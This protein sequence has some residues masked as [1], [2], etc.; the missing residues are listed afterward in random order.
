VWTFDQLGQRRTQS[1]AGGIVAR[2]PYHWGADMPSFH[3]LV[4][5]VFTERMGGG[6][7]EPEQEHA[8][9]AWLDRVPAPQGV[10]ADAD[11]VTRGRDLFEDPEQGCASCHSGA[12]MSNMRLENVTGTAVKVPS[13]IGVGARAPYMHDGCAATLRDRFGACGGGDNHGHT[14]QLTDA[15]LSD[16]IAYLDSL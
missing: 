13:L 14:S 8:L 15:Q 3:A 1:L 6:A 16:L 7:V 11:A 2:A 4:D 5:N 10:V 12:L 9:L